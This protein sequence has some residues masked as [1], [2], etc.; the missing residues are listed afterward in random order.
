MDE[1]IRETVPAT[2]RTSVTILAYFGGANQS[3][4]SGRG[5]HG[6]AGTLRLEV[7][8]ACGCGQGARHAAAGY[9]KQLAD[10]KSVNLPRSI[11]PQEARRCPPSRLGA[12]F[13]SGGRRLGA[14]FRESLSQ[15]R[16]CFCF[17]R[18]PQT[19]R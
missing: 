4:Q 17:G 7:T 6:S 19:L 13:Q 3:E 15:Q 16:E 9:V 12:S 1:V 18:R 11:E 10:L 5:P 14:V 8:A 2:M